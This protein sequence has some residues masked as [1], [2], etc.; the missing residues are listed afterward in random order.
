MLDKE[1]FLSKFNLKKYFEASGLSWK[2]LNEIYDNYANDTFQKTIR[3]YCNE[4]EKYCRDNIDKS[5][6]VHSIRCR[7]KDPEH[8]IEKIIRKRGKEQNAKYR[9]IDSSNYTEII[10]DLIGLRILVMSKEEWEKV[11][12]E[13]IRIFPQDSSKNIHM[14]EEPVAYTRYGDRDIYGSKIKSEYSNKGYRS[15]HYIVKYKKFY[16]EIQVRTLAEEVYGEFDHMVKYP[17]RNDNNF[18]LRYTNTLSKLTD[19]IDELMSTCFQI[20]ENGWD[21]CNKNFVADTYLD[22]KNVSQVPMFKKTEETGTDF[23]TVDGRIKIISYANDK[24]F[25]KDKPQHGENTK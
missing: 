18:L 16:C 1:K 20:N 21:T 22:W 13:L 7:A 12:D 2:V 19:S 9:K 4:F 15:Q 11:Y 10:H 6:P 14:A 25:R 5:T 23:N 17:Y 8:V 24:L 3:S